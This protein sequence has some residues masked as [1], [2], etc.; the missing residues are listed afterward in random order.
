MTWD[1][2][3]VSALAG[4]LRTLLQGARLRA[5]RF[6]WEERELSLFF[7]TGTLRLQ[8]HPRRGWVTFSPAA[9]FPEDARP[10][11]AQ[12]TE[13][14]VP[15]DE[16]ILEIRLR[17]ARGRD[18]GIRLVAELMTNQWNALLLDGE[19][20]RIRHLLWTR[21]LE[22]RT[23]AV[24]HLYSPPEPSHRRGLEHP[25]TLDE[26]RALV[27]GKAP[28]EAGR[29][30]LA[31]VALTSTINLPSLLEPGGKWESEEDRL[32]A[33]L[34]QWTALRS[35]SSPQPCLLEI[36]GNKQPY[37]IVLQGFSH[38]QFATVLAAIKAVAQE[39][40]GGLALGG[41]VLER[42]E[43]AL[44]RAR[45]RIRG[46][47]KEMAQA[48]DPD[49]TREMANLLLARLGDVPRGGGSVTLRGFAGEDIRIPLDPALSPQEN[50]QLL[51]REAARRERVANRLPALLAEA[52][53]EV[54]ELEALRGKL[55]EGSITPQEAAPRIP[56]RKSPA[57]PG[58]K[59]EARI[60]FRTFFS[61][62][63]LEIRV[64]RGSKDNDAL[65]F[66]HSHPEDVWLHA[67]ARAG[68]HVILR[69]R[70]EEPPPQ[71]DLGEAA[72]LAALHSGARTSGVVP[73]DW[74]RRKYVRKPRKAPP[75]TVIPER[76]KTLFVEPD[77]ELPKR[78]ERKRGGTEGG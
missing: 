59:Q 53:E 45:G 71:K 10:L 29:A 51:Y 49:E 1:S 68:A 16:R 40:D 46:I 31:E 77:P 12:V 26:W 6:R 70:R 41:A 32:A 62:G 57:P 44:H 30:L 20:G 21:R 11:S 15:A 43:Q 48:A 9:E 5:H 34:R 19:G 74:T 58:R 36:S 72:N 39:Q 61:S 76:I 13:V 28:E 65:T 69:W 33:G 75:G 18:R 35:L 55:A 50:A 47:R 42:L 63:G 38:T 14:S 8:L 22:E 60:P 73:V 54:R 56:G 3:L 4:E 24:G 64:G 78:L 2:P 7:R 67:R 66:H 25:L 17:K 27:V 52:E 37:P 23:L